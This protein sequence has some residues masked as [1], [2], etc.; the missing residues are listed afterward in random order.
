MTPELKRRIQAFRRG[1][2]SWAQVEG[3]S[4]QQAQ[5]IATTACDLATAGR[6]EEARRLL[7]GLV[8]VNPADSASWAT[9][10]AVYQRLGFEESARSSW[11]EALGLDPDNTVALAHRGEA[12]LKKGDRNGLVDLE[13]ALATDAQGRTAAGR[14]ARA[15]VDALTC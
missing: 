8:G 14:R 2:L 13:R 9:L 15:L 12:R 6:L 1:Q 7:V 5:R 4:W 3:L 10:G 11:D